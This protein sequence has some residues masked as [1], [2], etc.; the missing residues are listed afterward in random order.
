LPRIEG[1]QRDRH[2]S[3]RNDREQGTMLLSRGSQCVDNVFRVNV[4]VSLSTTR[5][6]N[7]KPRSTA[8]SVD[9]SVSFHARV[10]LLRSHNH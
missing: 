1:A 10:I 8:I 6:R 9:D 3:R 2:R 7:V 5:T 4:N